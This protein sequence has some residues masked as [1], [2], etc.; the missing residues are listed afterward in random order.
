MFSH[1]RVSE[2]APTRPREDGSRAALASAA[3]INKNRPITITSTAREYTQADWYCEL[4][5]HAL[6]DVAL[7]LVLLGLQY[8]VRVGRLPH[9]LEEERLSE[10][11]FS[12]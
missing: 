2:R 8:V 11:P 1:A 12:T 7:N 6:Y 4:G 3:R 10:L 9:A 5:G